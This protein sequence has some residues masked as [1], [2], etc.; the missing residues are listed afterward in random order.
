[1]LL[2]ET[3]YRGDIVNLTNVFTIVCDAPR[4]GEVH[5][6]VHAY[7][8]NLMTRGAELPP[9][10]FIAILFRG[11]AAAC[12][13]YRVWLKDALNVPWQSSIFIPNTFDPGTV[14]TPDDTTE[15]E[16]EQEAPDDTTETEPEESE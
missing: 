6:S 3:A 15:T 14:E 1:M 12:K 13:A 5:H 9:K 16:P 8:T 7:S 2:L 11:T 4:D 10:G